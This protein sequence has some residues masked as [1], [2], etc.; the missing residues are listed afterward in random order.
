MCCYEHV[1]FEVSSIKLSPLDTKIIKALQADAR[2]NYGE[3]AKELGV[4]KN[5]VSNRVKLLKE[6]GLITG[7]LILVNL[8]KF[9]ITCIATLLIKAIPSKTDE[10][11]TYINSIDGVDLCAEA[12]GSSNVM[13]FLFLSDIDELQKIIDAIKKEPSVIQ[14][15]TS[16]WT[17]IETALIRPKNISLEN[18][19]GS[20]I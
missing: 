13:A 1:P 12:V 10:V 14:V 5:T 15:Q 17:R 16:I 19:V 20:N 8:T 7:S 3:L 18:V 6:S 9:G 2:R 11:I 4:S